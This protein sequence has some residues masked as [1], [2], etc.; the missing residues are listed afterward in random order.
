MRALGSKHEKVCQFG[1]DVWVQA[2]FRLLDAN[3]GSRFRVAKNREQAK[4]AK[5]AVR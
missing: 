5:S 1:K 4:I 2:Q 3:E